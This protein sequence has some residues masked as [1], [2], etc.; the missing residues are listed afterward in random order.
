MYSKNITHKMIGNGYHGL[1]EAI[2]V[3]TFLDQ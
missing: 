3:I 2:K 1:N